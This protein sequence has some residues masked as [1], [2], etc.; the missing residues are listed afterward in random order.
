ME[1]F[2]YVKHASTEEINKFFFDLEQERKKKYSKSLSILNNYKNRIL[3]EFELINDT[4][5][6]ATKFELSQ[7]EI[8]KSKFK[9]VNHQLG[10]R[11]KFNGNQK[12]KF[13]FPDIITSNENS[14]FIYECKTNKSDIDIYQKELYIALVEKMLSEAGVNKNVVFEFLFEN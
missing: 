11:Y 2:D 5:K 8:L 14:V 1:N 7:V 12:E 9:K 6:K 10:I 3:T 4:R 13:A